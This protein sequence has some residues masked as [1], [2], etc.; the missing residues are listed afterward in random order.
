MVISFRV[1][2]NAV[3]GVD[4]PDGWD[5][6]EEFGAVIVGEDADLVTDLKTRSS[7]F[8]ISMCT[9]ATNDD[10]HICFVCNHS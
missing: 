2:A 5:F 3:V 8:I 9:V 7:L 4:A 10:L 1:R 6:G